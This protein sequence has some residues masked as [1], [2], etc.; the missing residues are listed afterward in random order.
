MLIRLLE[1]TALLL[2]AVASATPVFSDEQGRAIFAERDQLDYGYVDQSVTMEMTLKSPSGRESH[3]RINLSK[4]EGEPGAGDK[5]L[6]VFEYPRDIEGTALLTHEALGANDD[7]QWLY[8]PAYKRTKRIATGDRS[9]SFAGTEFSYE[10]LTGD[11]F[12]DFE[13]RYLGEDQLDGRLLLRIDRIPLTPNSQ[14]SRQETWV[15]PANKQVVLVFMY[16]VK[17]EHIKT[18][19]ATDW[20]AYKD[21]YWRP[22]IMIMTHIQS[23]R[24]TLVKA[25]EYHLGV[26]LSEYDFDPNALRRIH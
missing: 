25:S 14:Y 23:G 17:G 12:E 11:K 15:D 1:V 5:A 26:G 22:H 20:V 9:G 4:L 13:Y 21:H 24:S 2:L 3:R 10:D 8:L 7:S 19:E 16:D 18:F 6:I